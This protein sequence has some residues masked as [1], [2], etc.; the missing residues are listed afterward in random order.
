MC[1]D[2]QAA[3]AACPA[4]AEGAE[5]TLWVVWGGVFTDSRFADLE[6][7]TE[8]FYGPFHDQAAAVRAWKEGTMRKVD[9]ASHR[10]TIML[11]RPVPTQHGLK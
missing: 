1:P 7:G 9:V 3:G 2:P 10:L 6:P 5:R 11:A 4:R 8:E